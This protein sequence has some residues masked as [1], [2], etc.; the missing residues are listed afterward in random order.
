M[1]AAWLRNL[2][3]TV[4]KGGVLVE[5]FTYTS[6]GEQAEW[7][8]VKTHKTRVTPTEGGPVS[9]RTTTFDYNSEGQLWKTF[10]PNVTQPQAQ[11][12]GRFRDWLTTTEVR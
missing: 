3:E 5:E 8:L 4:T 9:V 12:G 1:P 11:P 10:F 7:G 6:V 2:V